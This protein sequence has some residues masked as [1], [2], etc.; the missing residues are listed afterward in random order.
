MMDL[1]QQFFKKEM[2][3]LTTIPT[4]IRAVNRIINKPLCFDV[5]L[6][7]LAYSYFLWGAV[8]DLNSFC[9]VSVVFP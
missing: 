1:Y 5:Q 2:K 3:F 9:H 4:K 8:Q 7:Y 6:N